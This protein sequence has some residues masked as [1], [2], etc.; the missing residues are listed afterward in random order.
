MGF[1]GSVGKLAMK[2]GE[3]AI[4][5]TRK[6][7]ERH[8]EYKAEMPGKSDDDLLSIVKRDRSRSPLKAGAAFEELK[9]RGFSPEDI[10]A[11]TQR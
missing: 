10:N 6:A 7:A 11:A 9:N 5:E 2:A 1:W 8:K 4:D 3:A